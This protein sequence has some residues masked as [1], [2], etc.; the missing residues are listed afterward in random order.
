MTPDTFDPSVLDPI[1]GVHPSVALAKL[2]HC[3]PF[4]IEAEVLKM[5]ASDVRI[6]FPIGFQR[7]TADDP[8]N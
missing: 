3:R 6:Y 4:F 8:P 1:I 5:A 2:C 7:L